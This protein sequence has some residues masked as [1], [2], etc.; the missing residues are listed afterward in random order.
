MDARWPFEWDQENDLVSG[1]DQETLDLA[2]EYAASTMRMLTLYRVGG[3]ALTVM[4]SGSSCRNP[5]TAGPSSMQS[6][7]GGEGAWAGYVFPG[8]LYPGITL[9]GEHNGSG[10]FNCLCNVGV[11]GCPGLPTVY[12]V[13]PVGGV[14]NVTVDGVV[15]D[16]SAYAIHDGHKLVRVDDGVWPVCAGL[17]FTVTYMRGQAISRS[18][19]YAAHMLGLEYLKAM[20]GSP[21][22]C[23]LPQGVRSMTRQ[24]VQLE[25]SEDLFAGG[26]TGIREVDLYLAQ[27]NPYGLRSAPAVYSPDMPHPTVIG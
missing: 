7:I 22:K 26:K 12:L 17:D 16:P 15:L 27:F 14:T 8:A 10:G 2:A 13:P 4:P 3:E 18:G 6:L 5:L 23:R 19:K 21:Q 9:T 25:F 20:T 24:G 1:A 11:C